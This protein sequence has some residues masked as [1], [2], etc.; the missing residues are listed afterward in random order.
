L[1][2]LLIIFSRVN[3][4]FIWQKNIREF[5]KICEKIRESHFGIVVSALKY[6]KD[7]KNRVE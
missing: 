7:G 3:T 6:T 1:E 2:L 4:P 5:G